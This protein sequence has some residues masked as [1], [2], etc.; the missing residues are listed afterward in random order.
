M[1]PLREYRLVLY[2]NQWVLKGRN[3]MGG[4]LFGLGGLAAVCAIAWWLF[5]AGRHRFA[6]RPAPQRDS[7]VHDTATLETITFPAIDGTEI[8][9]W[10]LRPA[11]A[12]RPPVIL[13][14]PGLTG[15]KEGPLETF[16]WRFVDAGYAVLLMD[17][18]TFGGSGGA[19]RHWL[20]PVRQVEDYRAAIAFM[21]AQLGDRV[22]IAR[23]ALWGSSFSGSAA[24]CAA[25]TDAD[26]AAV[27]AQVPYLGG[28]PVHPP[29]TLQIAG[30]IALSIGET[31]GDAIAGVLGITLSPAYITTYGKPG[32]TAFAISKDNPSR[33]APDR[34]LH[35]FWASIPS[36]LRGGWEN[37]ML[38]RGLQNLDRISAKDELPKV[39]C[40]VLL[41]GAM[42]D[43]MIAFETLRDAART[44]PIGG[45]RF[46]Q[47]DCGHYDPYVA[48]VF[49]ENICAQVEFLRAVLPV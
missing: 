27:V 9:C 26:I 2:G 42:Q 47:F 5:F 41:I 40:P 13:M 3:A 38:V 46:V 17:F 1:W 6:V 19:P 48:P 44:L 23:I 39:R 37:K 24:V 10:L 36:P 45:S 43:D 34:N 35:P 16:A 49:E 32:E 22:E 29:S 15:T 18:R 11:N 33:H 12:A 21:R 28:L 31:I 30:Y 8:E 4:W 7:N 20:D 25:A 14:A